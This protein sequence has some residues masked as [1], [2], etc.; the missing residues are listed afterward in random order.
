MSAFLRMAAPERFADNHIHLAPR[1][2]VHTWDAARQQGGLLM[3]A[4]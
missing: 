1:G 3:Q 4:L 2:T